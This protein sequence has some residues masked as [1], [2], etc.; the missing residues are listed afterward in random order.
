[1]KNRTRYTIVFLAL[2]AYLMIY[3]GLWRAG[4]P[5]FYA[6]AIGCGLV[7]LVTKLTHEEPLYRNTG[8]KMTALTFFTLLGLMYAAQEI[9]IVITGVMEKGFNAFGLSMYTAPEVEQV[10][11]LFADSSFASL[12]TGFWPILLGPLVEELLYR[13]YAAKSFED[14]AGRV[15]AIVVSA[16]AFAVGHGRFHMCIHTVISGMIFAFLLFEYGLK[17]AVS[18]HVINNLGIIGIEMLL[19]GIFG[20][21][22]GLAVSQILGTAFALFGVAMCI[23][24]RKAI[25]AYI[26]EHKA[27][28]GEYKA[29]FLNVGFLVFVAYNFYKSVVNI[30]PM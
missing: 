7:Y 29:A 15:F 10:R 23:R 2:T 21:D 16:V 4:F 5:D 1:M 30:A 19:C 20:T 17:W 24:N 22:R 28:A 25:A 6:A 3:R 8:K 18:F 26:R 9:M 14:S 27:P 11:V 13:S 12:T